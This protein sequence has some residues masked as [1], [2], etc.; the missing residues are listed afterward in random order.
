MATVV[1]RLDVRP[2]GQGA[3]IRGQAEIYNAPPWSPP[4]K[5]IRWIYDCGTDSKEEIIDASVYDLGA[6]WPYKEKIDFLIISHFDKDHISG[7]PTLLRRY[8]F[9]RI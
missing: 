5:T 4:S 9:T 3:F 6:S 8:T 1:S 2:V 7:L